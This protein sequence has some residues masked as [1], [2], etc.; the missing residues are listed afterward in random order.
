MKLKQFH[1]YELQ[2]HFYDRSQKTFFTS[3]NSL[4]KIENI[5]LHF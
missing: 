5:L 1:E 4:G 2:H 3:V